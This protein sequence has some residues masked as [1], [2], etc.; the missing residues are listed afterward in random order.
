MKRVRSLA[1]AG[2]LL[3]CGLLMVERVTNR[4]VLH[5]C[6]TLNGHSDD[7]V[8]S[9]EAREKVRGV[10][11]VRDIEVGDSSLDWSTMLEFRVYTIEVA[12]GAALSHVC[13]CFLPLTFY[14][15]FSLVL[16]FVWGSRHQVPSFFRRVEN[17]G[18]VALGGQLR[19]FK[20]MLS[21]RDYDL[22]FLAPALIL[23][24]L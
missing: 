3:F 9:K 17:E 18:H 22:V 4:L 23:C 8:V 10:L 11:Y 13:L 6:C 14:S 2:V 19:T 24:V 16:A 1:L 20:V 15:Y 5:G 12:L 21:V 7:I